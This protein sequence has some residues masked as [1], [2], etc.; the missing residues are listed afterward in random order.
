MERYHGTFKE[1][2]KV[3]RGM[4]GADSAVLDG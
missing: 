3:M 4:K 1:R 2:N